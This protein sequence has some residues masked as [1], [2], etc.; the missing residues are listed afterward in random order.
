MRHNTFPVIFSLLFVLAFSACDKKDKDEPNPTPVAVPVAITTTGATDITLS[1]VTIGGNITEA[2]TPPYTE[3]GVCYAANAN[4]TVSDTKVIS[5]GS[6]KGTF[7]VSLTG[8]TAGATYHARA[9]AV[10][11]TSTVY[12][13]DVSFTML[14]GQIA[15]TT[16][17]VTSI[18]TTSAVSGGNIT[19]DG[20]S[21]IT[22]RGICWG[23]ASNPTTANSKATSGTGTGEFTADMTELSP[24][25]TYYVRAYA[26]NEAGTTYGNEVSF[27]TEQAG[28]EIND[29][30]DGGKINI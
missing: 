2:G 26:V 11:K 1:S 20:G 23:T 21:S 16:S 28:N 18:T 4:P 27:K 7:T 19:A 5:S 15:L 22:E 25:T 10:S 3:R 30:G 13:A 12:G 24:N 17:A 6:G 8:L 14:S 29:W 9:Y